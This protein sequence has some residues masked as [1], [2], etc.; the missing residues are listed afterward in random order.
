MKMT[1][2]NEGFSTK[3]KNA[4]FPVSVRP[5]VLVHQTSG[6]SNIQA[7]VIHPV[8]NDNYDEYLE[9][10]FQSVLHE[11]IAGSLD[12][13]RNPKIPPCYR[14]NPHG[15]QKSHSPH[16]TIIRPPPRNKPN[17]LVHSIRIINPRKFHTRNWLPQEFAKWPP[18]LTQLENQ[19]PLLRRHPLTI[20]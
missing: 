11:L 8:T 19:Q 4:S 2:G 14:K 13:F 18:P 6:S 17:L 20:S 12:L 16:R 7:L 15:S 9:F 5:Q 10:T 1:M 3:S